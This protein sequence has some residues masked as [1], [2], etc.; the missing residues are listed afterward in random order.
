LSKFISFTSAP[1]A[2]AL[3]DAYRR[4]VEVKVILDRS[5][6]TAHYSAATFLAHAG[7]LVWIDDQHAIAQ[8]K[9]MIIDG[10]TILTVRPAGR[11]TRERAQAVIY[12]QPAA[13]SQTT[14]LIL[15][16]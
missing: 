15:T 2:K 12:Q 1:I 14:Q 11:E 16:V 7:I 13:E 4:G 10:N 9:I 5:N 6:R 3:V 8:N